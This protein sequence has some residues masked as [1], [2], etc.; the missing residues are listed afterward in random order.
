MGLCAS[1]A[2]KNKIIKPGVFITFDVECSMGG[3]WN[4]PSLK[5]IPPRLGMMGQYG[6]CS[7][8]LPLICDNL[9][10][11]NLKAHMG[12][13][14]VFFKTA[15]LQKATEHANKALSIKDT[16]LTACF[17]TTRFPPILPK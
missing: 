4:D 3:A 16:S 6:E 14:M 10:Q 8:G 15:K 13:A 2:K 9:N 1:V 17:L 11:N 7:Y 5:P 12:M